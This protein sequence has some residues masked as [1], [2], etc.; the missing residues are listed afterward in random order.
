MSTSLGINFDRCHSIGEPRGKTGKKWEVNIWEIL[1]S[2][3]TSYLDLYE[4][5]QTCISRVL[6][7]IEPSSR[8]F[9]KLTD[10]AYAQLLVAIVTHERPGLL[11]ST[12][13]L[14][15]LAKL[16]V[17]LEIDIICD[18]VEHD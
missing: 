6:A 18:E 5:T 16:N 7:R 1:E 14:G 11:F 15:A 3:Q 9:R 17:S 10:C 2:S 12:Q 4:E 13:T 8:I